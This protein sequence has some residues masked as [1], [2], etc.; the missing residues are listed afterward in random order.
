M[1]SGARP[2]RSGSIELS[3]HVCRYTTV[4][5]APDQNPYLV[6]AAGNAF[7]STAFHSVGARISIAS[8]QLQKVVVAAWHAA[9]GDDGESR[10]YTARA[11]QIGCMLLH[12]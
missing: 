5:S 11:M 1:L 7:E 6:K 8:D 2:L 9:P 4:A 10:I 12:S 3:K